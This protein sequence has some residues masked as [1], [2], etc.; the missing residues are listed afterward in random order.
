MSAPLKFL[1][2][3]ATGF[4]GKHLTALLLQQGHQLVCLVRDPKKLDADIAS[5]VEVLRGDL[6]LFQDA[7]LVLP[8]SMSWCTSRR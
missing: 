6:S 7:S 4:I 8:R 3:G 5:R 2:T 1:I